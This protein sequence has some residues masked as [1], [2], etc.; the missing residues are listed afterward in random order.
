MLH[1]SIL[2]SRHSFE[3]ALVE[4]DEA[5]RARPDDA[6]A[7]LTRATVLRVLGRYSEAASACHAVR[8]PGRCGRQP[9]L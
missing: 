1:A 6:Q 8:A 7:W 9:D 3:A 4:L 2:Q 5:L